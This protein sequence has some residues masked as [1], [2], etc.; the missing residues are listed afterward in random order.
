MSGDFKIKGPSK[1]F[2]FNS[3]EA[4][5]YAVKLKRFLAKKINEVNNTAHKT[6][7]KSR[8]FKNLIDSYSTHILLI[9][10]HSV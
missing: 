7:Y 3:F 2:K 6:K 10:Q 9:N 4:L 1:L 5:E 8:I